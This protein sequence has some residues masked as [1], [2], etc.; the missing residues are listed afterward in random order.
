MEKSIS[1]KNYLFAYWKNALLNIVFNLISA[2]FSLFSLLMTIPFLR[3][4]F[5]IDKGEKPAEIVEYKGFYHL[6]EFLKYFFDAK[7]KNIIAEK[8]NIV[9]LEFICLIVLFIFF[10]KNLFRY[11]AI[12]ALAPMRTGVI[13]EIRKDLHQ[14]IIRL[15]IDFFTSS[16][17]GD[18]ISRMTNDVQEIEFGILHFLEVIFKEPVNIIATLFMMISISPQLTLFVFILLPF[19]AIII[20]G[21][22]KSLKKQS[23]QSQER[24]SQLVS[25]IEETISGSKIFKIFNAENQIQYKF[26]QFNAH[27]RSINTSIIRKR[28]LSSPLSEFL[29]VG[30]VVSLLWFGGKMV[31]GYNQLGLEPEVFIAFIVIFTQI[32][33]PAKSLSNAFYFYQ[34][35]I[36]SF[37]RVKELLLEKEE[38]NIAIEKPNKINDFK[39]SL[40]VENVS[41]S[42][43]DRLVLDNINLDIKKGKTIALVGE[44][45]SGKT[46]LANII[47]GFYEVNK[48]NIELDKIAIDTFSKSDYRSLFGLVTQE[49][50]LFHDT[51]LNNLLI[52]KHD[53][54]E[55]EIE[56]ALKD[57]NAFDFVQLLSN[58]VHE[59]IGNRGMKLSGG[60]QQRLTIARALIK[61]PAILILDEATSNLDSVSEKLV[62]DAIKKIGKNR[63]CIIIAHRLSTIQS[64]DEIV[65]MKAGKIVEQGNHNALMSLNGEYANLNKDFQ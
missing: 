52:G 31:L 59:I 47:C 37:V 14:K 24:L 8:G 20:G 3:I 65:V 48:G 62:Q 10:I 2:V 60:E 44:S 30:V 1:L 63:T 46:T 38:N 18:I 49:P 26:D 25:L 55:K 29:G 22:S 56:I 41:F 5:G 61:N 16:K 11:L 21:I 28:D 13:M 45:G 34:K 12:H 6:M 36:A 42:Y 39:D 27:N 23:T 43:G 7:I 33:S 40:C 4:L 53:A 51:I 57:A 9:A 17:K 50:I 35:G 64:A 32:I 58:G 19:S 15:P 54:N